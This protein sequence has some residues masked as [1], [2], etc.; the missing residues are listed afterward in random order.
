VGVE[1]SSVTW[2][3]VGVVVALAVYAAAERTP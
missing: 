3:L 1:M 2:V